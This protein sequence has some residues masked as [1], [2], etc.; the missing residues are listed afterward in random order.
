M[1]YF[2]SVDVTYPCST[3]LATSPLMAVVPW[4]VVG[5]NWKGKH[6]SSL[7]S[8]RPIL[9]TVACPNLSIMYMFRHAFVGN[10]LLET[11]SYNQRSITA[12]DAFN[13]SLVTKSG[14]STVQHT[15]KVRS[16]EA[17]ERSPIAT[18]L[19]ALGIVSSA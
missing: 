19:F 4:S 14:W 2:L 18:P 3:S 5:R 7:V 6:P 12:T 8:T 10:S 9:R 11:G 15:L 16:L 1:T 13:G 17:V